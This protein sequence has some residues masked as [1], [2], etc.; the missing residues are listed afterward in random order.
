[1]KIFPY[2]LLRIAG[3]EFNKLESLNMEL[4]SK[5]NEDIFK[6]KLKI[7][8]LKNEICDNLYTLIPSF[9]DSHVQNHILNFKRNIF[10]ERKIDE[11]SLNEIRNYLTGEIIQ[12]IDEFIRLEDETGWLMDEGEKIFNNELNNLRKNFRE[13]A[14]NE[15]LQKGLV[16]SSQSLFD[17]TIN[18]I[19]KKNDQLNKDDYRTEQSLIKYIS[20][21]SAKTSP[22][23]TF[24]NLTMCNTADNYNQAINGEILKFN[25]EENAH[26]GVTSHIRINNFLFQ[27]LKGLLCKNPDIFRW[28]LIRPNPTIKKLEN[29]YLFLTNCN[30][31]E[32]FQRIP[33]NPALEV[34][35]ILAGNK[36]EGNVFNE[37]LDDIIRNEYIDAPKE[38]LESFLIQLI[39]YGF[40]EFNF[41]VSG[42]DPDW[43][44]KL[45]D[46]L[47]PLSSKSVLIEELTKSLRQIRILSEQYSSESIETRKEIIQNAYNSFKTVCLM[48]HEAAGLPEEERLEPQERA[49][50]LK[51]KKEEEETN[52]DK[53]EKEKAEEKEEE[54]E[55]KKEE[56]IFRH[57]SNTYF[58]YKP[59]QLFLEDT[60][61]DF[62]P[63]LDKNQVQEFTNTLNK[64]MQALKPLAAFKEE[65]DKMYYYFEN[66]YD[67]DAE[68]DILTFYEDYFREFKKPEAE[69]Q[70]EAKRKAKEEHKTGD[71][72]FAKSKPEAAKENPENK[73]EDKLIQIP[74]IAK[75][76]GKNKLWQEAFFSEI[77]EIMA[78]NNGQ[79]NLSSDQ[80]DSVNKEINL[81]S[82]ENVK[83]CSYGVFV[84]LF[85]EKDKS[86]NIRLMGVINNSL[87]G[88]GKFISRFLHLFP[89]KVTD[90][91]RQ[92][93]SRLN[94]NSML[95]EDCD[96]SHFNANL[97]PTLLPYEVWLPASQNS[98][99]AEKQIP[100]TDLSI[101]ADKNNCELKLTHVPS[102]K[103]V[104]VFD[105]GFQ[106][107]MG[108]SHLFQI[109]EK[110]SLTEVLYW[111]SILLSINGDL[112]KPNTEKKQ[113]PNISIR[114]RVIY[115][116][117][118]VL[119]RKAWFVPK[120]ILP[121]KKPKETDWQYFERI[122][123]WR[124]KNGIPKEIFIYIIN[125]M[126]TENINQEDAKKLSRD[127]YKPQYISFKNPFL[128]DLLA[129][130]LNKVPSILRIEEMLPDSSHLLKIGDK[131]YVGEFVL[132]W[133]KYSNNNE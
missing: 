76:Q 50:I 107:I 6:K 27:Y 33:A 32:S 36:P 110:F 30:N 74:S 123:E 5:K 132:Q 92:W 26:P 3:I 77:K 13:L 21:M 99:P 4:S 56:E 120:E 39:E 7:G 8:S 75:R 103:E 118:I 111:H 24:T 78:Q 88:F 23:S 12:K 11:K 128:I 60:S 29:E 105:L 25:S 2:I 114:P 19:K 16:I 38:D 15:Q 109:L 121:L 41:E 48:L 116:N 133:Y 100:I 51:A 40:L 53:K 101:K 112:N 81:E 95:A 106:S 65:K 115:E 18:Y 17:R 87:P 130:L 122:N 71:D 64:L 46:K 129:K 28:F 44:K 52:K 34:F 113:T 61:I 1:M 49:K 35:T 72:N 82:A 58:N 54:T 55:V 67:L 69:R 22:F 108:R 91:L 89:E 84:Q 83:D 96:E 59:E 20:R 37:I 73:P 70:E 104:Y 93:N 117:Q 14:N 86:G 126:E 10:N 66:K 98:L 94:P 131:K 124:T 127:D 90:E 102:G 45:V 119:Q 79:I 62:Q 125:R 47:L 68:I 9:T 57:K 63:M 31:V 42:I 80:I 43:D 85:T 97:H